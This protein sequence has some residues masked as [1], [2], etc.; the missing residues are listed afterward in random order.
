M[1]SPRTSRRSFLGLAAAAT[2]GAVSLAAL[3]LVGP[4]PARRWLAGERRRWWRR[5]PRCGA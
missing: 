2:L 5:T 1:T 4:C 3:W